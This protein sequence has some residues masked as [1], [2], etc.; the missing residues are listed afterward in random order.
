MFEYSN[1][2]TRFTNCVVKWAEYALTKIRLFVIVKSCCTSPDGIAKVIVNFIIL[3]E[4]A[5]TVFWAE[6]PCKARRLR[7]Q[8][9]SLS[10]QGANPVR[11]IAA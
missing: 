11:L 10:I 6:I 8:T 5:S 1:T 9:R 4:G 3:V 2:S 7:F